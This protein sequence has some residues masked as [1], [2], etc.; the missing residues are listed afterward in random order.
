MSGCGLA[1]L[2]TQWGTQRQSASTGTISMAFSTCY[3]RLGRGN[4]PTPKNDD[5]TGREQPERKPVPR[6]GLKPFKPRAYETPAER[7]ERARKAN[8]ARWAK[9]RGG[10]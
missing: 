5:D 3:G 9:R 1:L 10:F 7:S 2:G 4:V 6:D 8:L